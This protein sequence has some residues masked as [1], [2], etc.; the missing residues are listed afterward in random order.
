MDL[1]SLDQAVQYF[2]EYGI[3]ESTHKTYQSALRKFALFC[4]TY[5]I[6]SPFPV[7][8][9]LLCYYSSFLACKGL[10][11]QTIK[12][13]LAALRHTQVVLGKSLHLA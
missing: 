10:S 5:S 6:L 9:A 4:S 1:T 12:T 7:S 8:E 2:C 3:A 11:P 13:Y